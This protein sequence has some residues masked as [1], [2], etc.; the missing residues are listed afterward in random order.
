LVPVSGGGLLTGIGLS[1]REQAHRP[2]LIGVQAEKA[3]FM[4]SLF[5]TDTQAGIPDVP[6]IADGLTGEVEHESI[7]IPLVKDMVDEIVLVSEDEIAHA[8]AFTWNVYGE[9]LEG[10]GAVG[11]A[12]VLSNKVKMRPALV[13]VSGGN[14]GP[15][16]HA[17]ILDCFAGEK[18]D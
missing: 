10:S 2:R 8:M 18:W 15:E 7:T 6:S 4:H 9:K 3:P 1:L 5:Y 17:E 16:T 11:L 13:V 14:V 12:A